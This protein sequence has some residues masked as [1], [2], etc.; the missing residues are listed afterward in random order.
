[1]KSFQKVRKVDEKTA[2]NFQLKMMKQMS[3]SRRGSTAQELYQ[4]TVN[5][6][7]SKGE[8]A[9]KALS[10]DSDTLS[11]NYRSLRKVPRPDLQIGKLLK[12]ISLY[13]PSLNIS[14]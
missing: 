1:M 9:L 4:E 13:S 6:L 8:N 2:S 3:S 11:A 12:F 10:K 5:R 7:I 14:C